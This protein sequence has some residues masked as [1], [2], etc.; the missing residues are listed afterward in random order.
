MSKRSR[1]LRVQG[2]E[3][4]RLSSTKLLLRRT[5]LGEEST[6]LEEK[7]QLQRLRP[8]RRAE[9]LGNVSQACREIGLARSLY[10]RLRGPF[11]A[12]G[13]IGL[14]PKHRRGRPGR[15]L[16]SGLC[17]RYRVAMQ[18]RTLYARLLGIED[19]WRVKDVTLRLDEEQAVVVSVE[20]DPVAILQCPKCQCRVSGYDSRE[21]RWR[22]LDTMQYRT[23]LVADVP[24]GACD[25]HGVIQITVLWSDPKS[26]LTA[27]FEA[28]VINWLKEASFAALARQLSLS[29]DPVPGIQDR[30]LRRGLARRKTQRPCRRGIDETS[31][32]KGAEY[33]T[34]A[35]DLDQNRLLR[36]G[37]NRRKETPNAFYAVLGAE[38][39]ARLQ[40][41]AMD[42]WTRY[43][44]STRE[45]VPDADRRI[46]IRRVP[47]RI[48]SGHNIWA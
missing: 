7:G 3:G 29:W 10:D 23:I 24:R 38:G 9:E 16:S 13:P 15:P 25:E 11:L 22:H 45:H 48:T 46:A 44:A 28:L 18:D 1:H 14:H 39:C 2:D 8:F 4:H 41:V 27:L 17:R 12:Y 19:P 42:M 33:I 36:V 37:E 26:R 47:D 34:V 31:F 35:N 21:Q 6:T 43:I 20:M 30:A 5:H 32:R 40:S